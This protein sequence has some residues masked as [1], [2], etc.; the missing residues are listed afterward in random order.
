MANKDCILDASVTENEKPDL[1]VSESL[2][3]VGE[4]ERVLM[5]VEEQDDNL[6]DETLSPHSRGECLGPLQ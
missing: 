4:S 6:Y 5:T 1:N 3:N 2:K